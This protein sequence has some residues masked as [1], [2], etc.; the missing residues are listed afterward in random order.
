MLSEIARSELL[1]RINK[2][3]EDALHVLLREYHAS[4]YRRVDRDIEPR[5]C[6][7]VDP[8]DVLQ[9]AYIT[10]FRCINDCI[11]ESP[12]GFYKWIEQI[13]LARLRDAVRDLKRQKRDVRRNL[14]PGSGI[15]APP[16]DRSSVIDLIARIN[17]GD[18]TP[19]GKLAR[20]ELQAAVLTALARL[21]DEQRQV[22]RMRFLEDRPT[23]DVAAALGKSEDAVYALC[24]RGLKSLRS[25]VVFG[26]PH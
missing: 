8:E 15:L 19:S 3:D 9:E 25:Y 21:K 22:I 14:H 26:I 1:N 16:G 23:A 12:G 17:A 20:R 13:A 24:H 10:A 6:R 18:T 7:Y 5:M 4:I 2:G 11:F